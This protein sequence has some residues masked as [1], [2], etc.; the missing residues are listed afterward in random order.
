M[1]HCFLHSQTQLSVETKSALCNIIIPKSV[2][3]N[4]RLS[5]ERKKYF[6]PGPHKNSSFVL[7]MKKCLMRPFFIFKAFSKIWP[8]VF[9][10]LELTGNS[11]FSSNI[12]WI[13]LSQI[14]IGFL[15]VRDLHVLHSGFSWFFCFKNINASLI[16]LT[17]FVA[18]FRTFFISKL[19]LHTVKKAMCCNYQSQD[20]LLIK[21]C[22]ACHAASHRW[23]T[24]STDDRSLGFQ[25]WR[26]TKFYWPLFGEAP[27]NLKVFLNF[28]IIYKSYK[29]Y[30][31]TNIHE[32][33]WFISSHREAAA[34]IQ[35]LLSI[36]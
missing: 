35:N 1:R 30:S 32:I 7:A 23:G 25:T 5:L 17:T 4:P 6:S 14:S 36:T 12:L 16:K 11:P 21:W 15:Y 29:C 2:S 31:M 9:L 13:T 20:I 18:L 19:F 8:S 22:K 26:P 10:Y 33:C 24:R 3:F 27:S 34:F 28:L